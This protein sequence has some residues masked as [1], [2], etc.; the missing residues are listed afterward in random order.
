MFVPTPHSN[1]AMQACIP[2]LLLAGMLSPLAAAAGVLPEGTLSVTTDSGLQII[3][4]PLSGTELVALQLWVDV[5]SRD[6]TEPGST[7]Y[8]H[9]F[10][11]LMFRG[12]QR[13]TAQQRVDRLLELGAVDN[14][15]TSTDHTC[16]H[17][18]ARADRLEELLALEAD[19][20]MALTLTEDAV[21]RESGAVL[22]EFRKGRSRPGSVLYET[23]WRT[24]F[25]THTYGHDTSGLEEDVI[26]MPEGLPLT[27]RFFSAWYRPENVTVVLAGDIDPAVAVQQVEQA[28]A[29]WSP[30]PSAA[31]LPPVPPEPV[32]TEPRRE[33]VSWTGSDTPPR[34]A[35]GW[36]MPVLVPGEQDA[37]GV[38]LIFSLLTAP[39]APLHRRLIEEEELV[40][41]LWGEAPT[42]RDPGLL[43]L[44]LTLREGADPARVEAVI[45]E[46]IAALAQL[47]EAQLE[48]TRQRARRALLLYLDAPAAWAS[49]VGWYTSLGGD[50]GAL[51]RHLAA[52]E[53]VTTEDITALIDA[54]FAPERRTVVLLEQADTQERP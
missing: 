20:F 5:G 17:L 18:V 46:E 22:G 35:I 15:W 26:A 10:E 19:R 1:T 42:S 6:E 47:P 32:Q 23:L 3:A 53:A 52:L 31:P 12:S 29:G 24:A 16:Y 11:H 25:T 30:P 41:S 45:D 28:F 8:A 21:R 39:A 44:H 36:K 33:H 27:E 50:V 51:D 49:A 54:L 2:W 14:A 40:W 43:A 4:L 34:L 48:A 37:A 7:G 9:F 13:F 38:D